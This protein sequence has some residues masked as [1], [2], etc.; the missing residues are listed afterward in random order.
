MS[1]FKS[2]LCLA[3]CCSILSCKTGYNRPLS[4]DSPVATIP[5]EPKPADANASTEA[6]AILDLLATFSCEKDGDNTKRV[7]SGQVLGS[8]NDAQ[9]YD[10]YNQLFTQFEDTNN[11]ENTPAV[12]GIDYALTERSSSEKLAKANDVI[13]EHW[14]YYGIS[15]V[16]WTPANPWEA[17]FTTAHTSSVN[18]DNLTQGLAVGEVKTRWEADIQ[19]LTNAL[20]DLQR[21]RIPV[22]FRPFP[23]MNSDRYW[24]GIQAT[25]DNKESDFEELWSDLFKRL[26]DAGVNNIVWAY[27]PLDSAQS[28]TKGFDWGFNKEYVDI[29]APV[30]RN[31][32]LDIRDYNAYKTMGKPLG[33]AELSPE[34]GTDGSFDNLKYESRLI[35]N[36]PA[37]AFWLSGTNEND[38]KRTLLDNKN[39]VE[40]LS[41]DTVITAEK[42]D[43]QNLLVY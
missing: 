9:N 25:G 32:N 40:L 33:L 31:N 23:L 10:R 11:N 29:V 22:I 14:D 37:M 36:Y 4:T 38:I 41:K 35:T 21:R 5:C 16:S 26:K 17:S 1:A 20:M 39:T 24:W 18:L 19:L 42:I 8:S 7:L 13:E 3:L 27:S 12:M 6:L 2:A 28:N 34:T 43:A 30:I 15:I